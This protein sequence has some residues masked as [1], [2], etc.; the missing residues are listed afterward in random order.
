L[1][2]L[3]LACAVG[4]SN[5][6]YNQPLLAEMA[7][8]LRVTAAHIGFVAVATQVGYA[9]GLLFFVPLGDM[10]ERRQ[11]MLRMYAAVSVA[12]LIVA[13]S[14]N[15]VCL[16]AA[17]VLLGSTA[18]V[19]HVALP[20]APDM[21]PE[22]ARG[23]AIGTVMMGLLLGVLLA[24]TFAG[25]ISHV[26]GWV[27]HTWGIAPAYK[28]VD[29]GWRYVFVI[30]ALVSAAFIPLTRRVMPELPPKQRL[31]YREVME[32]LWTL[33]RTQPLL[34]EAG[35]L[36]A[37][38]F[39]SFSCFWT[40]LAFLLNSRYGLGPGVA[41]S[42]GLVGAAGAMIAP[43]AGKWADRRGVRWVLTAGIGALAISFVLLWAGES[44]QIPF[45]AHMMVL[46]VGVL[47]LDVGA[48]L[49]QVGN[50][51]RI[52]GLVPSARSRINTVYMTIYFSGAATGSAVSAVVWTHWQWDG[53]CA[54]ALSFIALAG[55][56]H[57]LGRRE[58]APTAPLDA[59]ELEERTA[60]ESVLEV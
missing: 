19:T 43:M 20:I 35:L 21:V 10:V 52:F 1:R 57:A 17:S 5:L 55:L 31:S 28:W 8:S 4:V 15:L 22:K 42:F 56:R 49:S 9:A 46:V 54:L 23:R 32:S 7:Q 33:F 53:V 40:T 26:P 47:A 16:I 45:A 13:A 3:G 14:P 2:F 44:V 37:L 59:E 11:L 58:S 27:L 60:I 24:R 50:Q 41:G 29:D 38:V 48:Q 12:L 51:T 39:A 25:W 6:Y 30:A 18:S 34:R 36:C